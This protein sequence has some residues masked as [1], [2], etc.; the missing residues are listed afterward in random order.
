MIISRTPLRVSFLG[1][2]TD[3]PDYFLNHGGCVLS[4]SINKYI[5]ISVKDSFLGRVRLN[6]SKI[7]DVEN[8]DNL[9]HILAKETFRE[10]GIRNNIEMGSM[11]EIPSE[12]SGLGSSSAYVV[13]AVKC[14]AKLKNLAYD[15]LT[16]AGVACQIEI[17]RCLLPIGCQDQY[18]CA[19]GGLNIID[20]HKRG[21]IETHPIEIS[22]ENLDELQRSLMLLFTGKT[23]QSK[24]I[25][26]E[27]KSRI[28]ENLEQLS[29]MRDMVYEGKQCLVS[30]DLRKFGSLIT[31][32]WELKKTLSTKISDLD[33]DHLVKT[34]IESGAYG[35][36]ILG[37]GGGGFLLVCAPPELHKNILS[38]LS[39][40]KHIEFKFD[41][42]GSQ[43]IY[44]DN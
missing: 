27:Q 35:A 34:A 7:E 9:A 32:S 16:V 12:G 33:I 11:S 26:T 23:R 31:E 15:N 28:K 43:I 1:G 14:L 39:P 44:A 6:Y 21:L 25:L 40:L 2:G 29:S 20:F 3:F 24:D 4:T 5:Y 19:V 36:K 42:T 30:G 8:V 38:S 37:S 22:P 41:T 18:S 13:G 17:D 10:F